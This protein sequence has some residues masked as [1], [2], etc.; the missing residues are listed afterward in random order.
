MV[1]SNFSQTQLLVF[2]I[3]AF[4]IIISKTVSIHLNLGLIA[5]SGNIQDGYFSSLYRE[6]FISLPA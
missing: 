2:Q 6:S 4:L 3:Q 5:H 1:F